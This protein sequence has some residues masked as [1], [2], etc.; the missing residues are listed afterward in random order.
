VNDFN[1]QI[2]VFMDVRNKNTFI[3]LLTFSD[4]YV[5]FILFFVVGRGPVYPG[6]SWYSCSY[7]AATAAEE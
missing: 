1:T 5:C 2:E 3:S 6:C 4:I 7:L